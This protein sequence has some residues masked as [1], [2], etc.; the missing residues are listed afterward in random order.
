MDAI[1]DFTAKFLLWWFLVLIGI[2]ASVLV[3]SIV[4]ALLG[5]DD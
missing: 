3:Y 2:A 1:F 5:S 4:R